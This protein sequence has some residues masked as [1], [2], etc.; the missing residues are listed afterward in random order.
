MAHHHHRE[1][2]EPGEVG[3]GVDPL[4]AA[5]PRGVVHREPAHRQRGGDAEADDHGRRRQRV[6]AE[7]AREGDGGEE[8]HRH[9]EQ[10]NTPDKTVWGYSTPGGDK[11]L[12]ASITYVDTGIAPTQAYQK[13]VQR[14]LTEVF[15]A[16]GQ[17]G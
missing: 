12:T 14:L 15:C 17:V 13:A 10:L 6:T 3:V 16:G 7:P 11:T 5:G 2:H 4:E 8:H 9:H 1:E